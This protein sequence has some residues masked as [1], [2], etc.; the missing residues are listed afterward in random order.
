M[1]WA[2]IGRKA[3]FSCPFS[4]LRL[5]PQHAKLLSMKAIQKSQ[6]MEPFLPSDR[7]KAVFLN[8]DSRN[9][10]KSLQK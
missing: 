7:K 9:E 1:K 10:E 5:E 4:Q 8:Y 3:P 6:K 2:K